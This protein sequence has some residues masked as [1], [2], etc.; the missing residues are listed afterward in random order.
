MWRPTGR[1][2][3]P[4]AVLYGCNITYKSTVGDGALDIPFKR[5]TPYGMA[6]LFQ[7]R[8]AR[9]FF[10]LSFAA[11][12]TSF[13]SEGGTKE[14]ANVYCGGKIFPQ[15]RESLVKRNDIVTSFALFLLRQLLEMRCRRRR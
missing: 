15:N 2:L 12:K 14:S 10:V 5:F 13:A 9:I 7:A 3:P 1:C 4:H 6:A 8:F 11:R